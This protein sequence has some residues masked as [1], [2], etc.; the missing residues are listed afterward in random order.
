MLLWFRQFKDLSSGGADV[1]GENLRSVVAPGPG[2]FRST[3]TAQAVTGA[4]VS[5]NESA[6]AAAVYLWY[7][8]SRG[9]SG[10]FISKFNF[11]LGAK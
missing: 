4:T 9:I 2:R 5:I 10:V 3:G 11:T 6:T 8:I 1:G 7:G